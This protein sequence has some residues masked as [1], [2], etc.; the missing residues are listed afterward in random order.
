MYRMYEGGI[1]ETRHGERI[2]GGER[3]RPLQLESASM[4]SPVES[5]TAARSWFIGKM[6]DVWADT[7]CAVGTESTGKLSYIALTRSCISFL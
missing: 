3:H 7:S 2:D 5:T 1:C 4:M 6:S